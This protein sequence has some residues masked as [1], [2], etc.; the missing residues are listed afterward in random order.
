M[1]SSFTVGSVIDTTP[2]DEL[3]VTPFGKVSTAPH[4]FPVFLTVTV[5]SALSLV[6][7]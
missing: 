7:L 3:T 1:D 5:L 2:L 6:G 4:V